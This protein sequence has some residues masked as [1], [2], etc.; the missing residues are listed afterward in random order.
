SFGST[1]QTRSGVTAAGA[2]TFNNN[3]TLGN[4]D[5]G[6]TFTGLVTSGGS[7]GNSIGGFDGLTFTGGLSLVGG[8]VSV[9]SNG[10][11]LS[12]G[13]P[14]SGA[15]NLTLNA[16]AGGAGTVTGLDQ[17]GFTSNLTGLTIT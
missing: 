13:G 16:L 12:F 6:S 2:T 5:T 14:V 15:R 9:A 7:S 17:I 3:V 8:P 4:G 11:T 10:S 1:V